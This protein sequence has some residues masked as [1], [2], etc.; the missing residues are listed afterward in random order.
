[1][2][3]NP[4]DALEQVHDQIRRG[5]FDRRVVRTVRTC[6]PLWQA[7]PDERL[8]LKGA[9]VSF[10]VAEYFG[11]YDEATRYLEQEGPRAVECLRDLVDGARISEE[12]IRI[13]HKR[14]IWVAMAYAGGLY[15]HEDYTKALEVLKGCTD[16]VRVLDPAGEDLFGTRARLAYSVGQVYRQLHRHEDARRRFEDA[17]FFANRRF[18]VKTAYADLPGCAARSVDGRRDFVQD[19]MLAHWTIGKS[20]ALGLG[21]IAYTTGALSSA[22]MLISAGY[23]LLRPTR[24]GVH[25]AYATLL[26]GAVRRARAGDDVEQLQRAITLM[27]DAA[28]GLARHPTYTLHASYELALAYC[29]L[30]SRRSRAREEVR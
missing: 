29:R 4:H 2:S 9:S 20:M 14:R 8:R 21:W 30:E 5:D 19:R 22:N 6:N 7:L 16:A 18:T 13:L 28:E 26:L 1:M 10:E 3:T 12:E 23:A 11:H 17:V 27:E 24:D 25:R 15:R